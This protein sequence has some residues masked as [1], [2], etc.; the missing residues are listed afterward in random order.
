MRG[1]YETPDE[2]CPYCGSM[3][4]AEFVDVGVGMQQVSPYACPECHAEEAGPYSDLTRS[5]YDRATGWYRPEKA[6]P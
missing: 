2:P 4:S 5:D 6:A 1:P 3:C